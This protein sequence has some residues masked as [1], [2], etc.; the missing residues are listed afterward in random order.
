MVLSSISIDLL[1][2]VNSK[3]MYL[4]FFSSNLTNS[5]L[6]YFLTNSF[7][8]SK[9]S[10]NFFLSLAMFFNFL[11]TLVLL[12]LILSLFLFSSTKSSI[13]SLWI[14]SNFLTH[15]K[16]LLCLYSLNL[17]KS[18]NLLVLVSCLSCLG[19]LYFFF[20]FDFSNIEIFLALEVFLM[21]Y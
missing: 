7:A 14:V 20:L 8:F 13:A 10:F 15:Y 18:S 6:Q 12:I 16:E 17:I 3:D 2:V 19:F 5:Y 11:F 4:H 1:E 21:L 9:A